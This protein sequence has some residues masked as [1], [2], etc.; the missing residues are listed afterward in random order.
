MTL[1][2]LKLEQLSEKQLSQVLELDRICLGGLWSL[3]GYQRE[4]NSPN[5]TILALAIATSP[6]SQTIVGIG[7][8]WAILEEA[9]ITIIA[10][11]PDYQSQG[12][13]QLLLYSLLKDAVFRKLERATLEV[14]ASNYPA[15]S[16]YKKF[17]F[18]EAGKRKGYYQKTGEDA[19]VLWRGG[20]HQPEFVTNMTLWQYRIEERLRK[21]CWEL[22][23]AQ[24][25]KNHEG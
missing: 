12:F 20:L 22:L 14:R 8:F 11:H 1:L 5:S 2:E 9:H 7:C 17:G 6:E 16:L 24:K 4:L 18:K 13:G 25:I 10:V 19:I 23:T 3:S 15:L 21:N